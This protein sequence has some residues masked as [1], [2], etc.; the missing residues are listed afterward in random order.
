[1][2]AQLYQNTT[3]ITNR[4]CTEQHFSSLTSHCDI[5]GISFQELNYEKLKSFLFFPHFIDNLEI[6]IQKHILDKSVNIQS[7]FLYLCLLLCA[8]KFSSKSDLLIEESMKSC[9]DKVLFVKFCDN[10]IESNEVSIEF[11]KGLSI[12]KKEQNNILKAIY[13]L[14]SEQ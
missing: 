5:N 3:S 14:I 13:L 4:L 8:K 11:F 2:V 12:F 7:K 1:M 6:F 9:L 10:S